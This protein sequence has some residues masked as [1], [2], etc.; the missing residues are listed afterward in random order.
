MIKPEA[1]EM[2][3]LKNSQPGEIA[4]QAVETVRHE[5]I[6]ALVQAFGEAVEEIN[7]PFDIPQ[8]KVA[9]A[10]IHAVVTW[11]KEQG[12][13][14]LDDL[15]G[16]DYLPR[17][18]RFEVVYH[19]VAIPSLQR[20]RLRVQIAGDKPEVATISDLFTSAN[21]AEREVWDQFGIVFRNHPNLTRILNPEDWEGHPL[22]R[23][24]P[25]RGPR[26][27]HSEVAP[28]DQNRFHPIK[29]IEDLKGKQ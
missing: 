20:L 25:L 8:V 19:L 18:P 7:T 26:T 22:R 9:P 11:L 12:F 14:M 5:V 2:L 27:T 29:F 16:V 13:N 1:P 21:P 15:A 17:D 24:Y 23:D 6:P 3:A 10:K 4:A 28:A